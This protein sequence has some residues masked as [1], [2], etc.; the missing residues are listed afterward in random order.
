MKELFIKIRDFLEVLG[1]QVSAKL[2]KK[3]AQPD[4]VEQ[5]TSLLNRG[6]FFDRLK[7]DRE[8]DAME[9]ENLARPGAWRRSGERH[10]DPGAAVQQPRSRQNLLRPRPWCHRAPGQCDQVL[11]PRV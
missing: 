2:S 7:E 11:P 6:K 4:S 8:K 1:A 9:R 5:D 10:R 3:F